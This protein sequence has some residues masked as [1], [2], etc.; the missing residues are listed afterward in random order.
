MGIIKVMENIVI[1]GAGFGGLKAATELGKK[2]KWLS[3]RGY[4][5]VLIDKNPYHTYTPTLYE[6]ATTS[7]ETASH[8]D[9]QRVTTYPVAELIPGHKVKFIQDTVKNIDA[10]K[11]RVELE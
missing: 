1:L 11:A 5:V 8:L 10:R 3:K 7:K 9:L 6:V 2:A 4:Q